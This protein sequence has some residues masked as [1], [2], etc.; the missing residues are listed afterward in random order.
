MVFIFNIDIFDEFE[1][2]NVQKSSLN[3]YGETVPLLKQP[4]WLVG[5]ILM[6]L[7]ALID[8]GSFGLGPQVRISFLRLLTPTSIEFTCAPGGVNF[9]LEYAFFD[10][11]P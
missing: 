3:R 9:I 11:V 5:L 10:T 1:G 4:R 8:V 6:I 7:G 2:V